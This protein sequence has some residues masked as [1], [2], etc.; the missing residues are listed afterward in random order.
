MRRGPIQDKCLSPSPPELV[1]YDCQ[2]TQPGN[3]A[4]PGEKWQMGKRLER[5]STVGLA[6][7][8]QQRCLGSLDEAKVSSSGPTIRALIEA[9]KRPNTQMSLVGYCGIFRT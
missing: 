6:Q 7:E 4:I 2:M 3:H 5:D 9:H 1:T 8:Q